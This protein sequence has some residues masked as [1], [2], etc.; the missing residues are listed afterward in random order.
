MVDIK[1]LFTFVGDEIDEVITK[2]EKKLSKYEKKIFTI[3]SSD[4]KK[5][6]DKTQYI[7]QFLSYT[8]WKYKDDIKNEFLFDS[9]EFD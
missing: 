8:E 5:Y 4:L 6:F 1:V 3:E 7:E 2:V 9:L